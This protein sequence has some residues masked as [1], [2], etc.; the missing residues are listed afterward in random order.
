[1]VLMPETSTQSRGHSF[2]LFFPENSGFCKTEISFYKG[3]P[4]LQSV[5]GSKSD[6]SLCRLFVT[7][8]TIAQLPPVQAFIRQ[9]K[10]APQENDALVILGAGESYKT[11][12]SVLAIVRA[13][14]EQNFTRNSVFIGIGGGVI[15]D[16]TGFAAS[17]FKRGV[18]A[19]FVPTT[20]LADVDAAIGGKTGCDFESYKNMIGAF[21]PARAV[22][23]WSSFTKSLSERE[24]R[25]GLAEAIKTAF[26]FSADLLTYIEEYHDQI[27]A[28]DDEALFKIISECAAA[29]A[30]IVH[31]DF[32]EKGE[33]AFLNLGH[34]FGHALESV[35]GLGT[36]THGEGVAWGMGCAADLTVQLWP[37]CGGYAQRCK[38]LLALYGYDMAPLPSA[39]LQMPGAEGKLLDAMKKDKKNISTNKIR[40]ILN[41][42]SNDTQIAEVEDNMILSV[43]KAERGA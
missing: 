18:Q 39:L 19:E 21:Y 2:D 9:L 25:S 22:R 41:R 26:L 28:R 32:K 8:T 20:L 6:H 27:L 29:K 15:C 24:F 38:K 11:I 16:M 1:M 42:A 43:L 3:E 34:T 35:A 30:K 13:A 36:V 14:L 7:D 12:E 37:E 23:I 40:V 17:M 5:Y 4:D 33:R 31:E 10:S